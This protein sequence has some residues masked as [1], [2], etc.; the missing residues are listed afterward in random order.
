[1]IDESENLNE[2]EKLQFA[3]IVRSQLSHLELKFLFLNCI[4][5]YGENFQ[6][7]VG[8]YDL[9]EWFYEYDFHDMDN[10][11]LKT[12]VIREEKEKWL[13]V[14]TASTG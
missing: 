8:K 1:M 4:S 7:Y 5:D 2:E 11:I 13:K 12:K 14:A 10:D 9:L 6:Y 3:K